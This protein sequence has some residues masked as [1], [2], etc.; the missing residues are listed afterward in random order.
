MRCVLRVVLV[1][2]LGACSAPPSGVDGGLAGTGGKQFGGPPA[3]ALGTGGSAFVLLR[4]PQ[5]LALEALGDGGAGLRLSFEARSVD[6]QAPELTIT[7]EDP[8][9][10]SA[11]ME[12]TV[13][14]LPLTVS[15][16]DV[17]VAL[18]VL[19]PLATPALAQGT[20][21]V[22]AQ[23]VDRG[24]RQARARGRV[25]LPQT[26]DAGMPDGGALDLDAAVPDMDG[27]GNGGNP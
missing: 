22:E 17:C 11:L 25:V 24:G 23:L 16:G 13:M 6:P 14:A 10:L 21:W 27:G 15:R 18:D 19:V 7:V 2:V 9:G 20:V 5:P 3:L 12:P 26:L 1:M 8:S 4:D